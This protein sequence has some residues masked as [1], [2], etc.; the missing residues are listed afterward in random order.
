MSNTNL[1]PAG[2]FI[3][4]N[5]T[6]G[7][8]TGVDKIRVTNRKG[9]FTISVNR[10]VSAVLREKGF[11]HL[12][13][14]YYRI[15]QTSVLIFGKEGNIAAQKAAPYELT[16]RWKSK[17]M[18]GTLAKNTAMTTDV[19]EFDFIRKDLEDGRIALVLE[20]GKAL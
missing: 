6:R 13:Y 9:N 18:V 5:F 20:G 14:R 19:A 1:I 11:T 17:A 15:P 7:G 8:R 16:L 10:E 2:E 3:D 4:Y 12:T